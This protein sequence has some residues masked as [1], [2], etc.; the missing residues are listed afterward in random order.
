MVMDVHGRDLRYF[1]AVAEQLTF[2]GAAERLYVSQPALSKQIRKLEKQIGTALF[3]RGPR[4]VTL[5]AAGAALLPQARQVLAAW[6][7]G[8]A[9]VAAA[10]ATQA[11]VLTIGISTSPGRGILPAIRSRFGTAF[12]HAK[13]VL[14]QFSWEDPSAGLADGSSDVAFVWLPLDHARY[15]WHV[16]ATEPRLVALPST[17]R[18]ATREQIAFADLLA[19]PFLALPHS[20]GILRD[21]WLALDARDGRE[22]VIGAEVSSTEETYEALVNGDGVVLLATGNAPMVTR[23]GVV[24]RPVTGISPCEL[25]LAWRRDDTRPLVRGYVA[26]CG[27]ARRGR[28]A[29]HGVTTA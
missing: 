14:R 13:P 21:Y 1:V 29:E 24:C 15:D 10:K 26:A 20:A 4:S 25:A 23:D 12:P 6:E 17:H 2:T 19:E 11:A 27:L 28:R 18:L 9:A 3:V 7:L 8:E 5:T 22:P 16:V